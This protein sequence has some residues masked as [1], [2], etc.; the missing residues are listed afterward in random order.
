MLLSPALDAGQSH[1]I[2]GEPEAKNGVVRCMAKTRYRQP[3]QACEVTLRANGQLTV[4]F[5]EPQRAIT[6]GQS[7]VFYQDDTCLGGAVIER[8][9]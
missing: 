6:P 5:D 2:N 3:D 1:W 4:T 8:A 9:H 7:V